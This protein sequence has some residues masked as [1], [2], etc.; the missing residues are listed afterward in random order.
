VQLPGGGFGIGPARN[1]K[2]FRDRR[3]DPAA[4][5]VMSD[6]LAAGQPPGE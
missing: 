4:R 5:A 1:P 6:R 3:Y 2:R